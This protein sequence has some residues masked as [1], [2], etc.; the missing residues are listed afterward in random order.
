[1]K[2]SQISQKRDGQNIYA[3]RT[4]HHVPK[5]MSCHKAIVVITDNI[6]FHDCTYV[7]NIY[8]RYIYNIYNI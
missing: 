4:V 2:K 7:Y 5:C 6:A 3:I 1:M 8:N